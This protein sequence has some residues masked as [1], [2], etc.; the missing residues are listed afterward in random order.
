MEAIYGLALTSASVLALVYGAKIRNAPNAPHWI[1]SGL[2][3]QT[4]LFSTLIGFIFGLSMI[5]EAAV[6][7]PTAG[8]GAVEA[9]LL[10]AVV[11][12]SWFC[13]RAIKRMPTAQSTDIIGT[14]ND[15]PTPA[16]NHAPQV[17]TGLKTGRHKRKVA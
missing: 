12:A 3:L 17:R 16:N 13:W 6:N 5:F 8:F 11:A 1:T 4:V 7:L 14:A 15:L 2:V 9:G 10:V